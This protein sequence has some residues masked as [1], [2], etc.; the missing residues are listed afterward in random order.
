MRR[1][2]RVARQ[3]LGRRGGG[4]ERGQGALHGASGAGHV[5]LVGDQHAGLERLRVRGDLVTTVANH[6]REAVGLQG[7][8]RGQRMPEHGSPSQRVQDLGCRGPHPGALTR[9]EDDDSGGSDSG[10]QDSRRFTSD[11]DR[12]HSTVGLDGRGTVT[13]DARLRPQDSNLDR[14]APKACVLPLHQGGP[15]PAPHGRGARG[16]CPPGQSA[17]RVPDG[18]A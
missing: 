9:G 5:V 15:T 2:D 3:R 14:K 7:P 11:D 17:S 1:A 18:T 16:P 4:V 8:T 13:P 12:G 10:H 6:H